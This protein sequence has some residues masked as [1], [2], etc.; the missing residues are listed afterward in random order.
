MD[1]LTLSAI[2]L[3][4]QEDHRNLNQLEF[5]LNEFVQS[6]YLYWNSMDIQSF[7]YRSSLILM[8]LVDFLQLHRLT[9]K[10][11]YLPFVPLE[12]DIHF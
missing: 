11:I 2:Q 9:T 1:N 5:Y 6:F 8:L 12:R 3:Q 7:L 4:N 10:R